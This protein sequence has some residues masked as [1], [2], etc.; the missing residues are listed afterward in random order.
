MKS[1][2]I[3]CLFFSAMWCPPC[4][5]FTPV[6]CE[7]YEQAN[8]YLNFSLTSISFDGPKETLQQTIYT[9]PAIYVNSCILSYLLNEKNIFP[10]AV[11]GHSL[12]EL[13]AL[14]S[15]G[16]ITF[17][18][19]LK[20]VKSRSEAMHLS[21]INNPGAMVAFIGVNKNYEKC[22]VYKYCQMWIYNVVLQKC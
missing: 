15:S 1:A 13:S 21:G 20:I 11:C 5:A 4:R 18:D 3:I 10:D 8:D 19:G 12:G 6:L 22:T 17:E 16:S 7:F 14:Y 2:E 9:Q